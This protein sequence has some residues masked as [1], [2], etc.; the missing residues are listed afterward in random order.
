M[1]RKGI[2]RRGGTSLWL[3]RPGHADFVHSENPWLRLW[4][5]SVLQGGLN[6]SVRQ[7]ERP[8]SHHHPK[9]GG[10]EGVHQNILPFVGPSGLC[11]PSAHLGAGE[12]DGERE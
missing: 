10:K 6:S 2:Q 9:T 4:A 7:T 11:T 1:D 12:R 8:N 3:T 5:L